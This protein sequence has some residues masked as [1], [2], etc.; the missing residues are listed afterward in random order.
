MPAWARFGQT[1][2]NPIPFV[3]DRS[4]IHASY[5]VQVWFEEE[6]KEFD[7]KAWPPKVADPNPIKKCMGGD[8][9]IHGFSACCHRN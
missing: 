2:E 8:G 5:L 9:D 4:P 1:E 3:H 7:V 6:G